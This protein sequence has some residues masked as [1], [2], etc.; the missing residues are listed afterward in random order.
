MMRSISHL[1]MRGAPGTLVV[2][3]RLDGRMLSDPAARRKTQALIRSYFELGN[4]QL[5]VNVVDQATLEAALADPE[6]YGE[7]VVRVAGYSEYWGR[8]T[9]ELRQTVLERTIHTA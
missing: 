9:P 7:L 1:D 4:M 3:M 8:L 6:A 5:Q 2:N